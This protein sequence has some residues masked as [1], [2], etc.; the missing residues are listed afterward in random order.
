MAN[1]LDP[2]DLKQILTLYKDGLSNRKIAETL[3]ISRNT[4]NS[5]VKRFKGSK[6]GIDEL[7]G[8]DNSKLEELFTFKTTLDIH[9]QDGLMRYFEQ[10][11][12]ARNHPGFTF[13]YRIR[14]TVY[15]LPPYKSLFSFV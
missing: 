7:L 13:Q 15:I 6:Y 2:M 5:Y 4:V 8:F 11:N 3:G 14:P 9:R 12:K 1:T 10:V